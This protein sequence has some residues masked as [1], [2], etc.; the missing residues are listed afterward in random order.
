M[1]CESVVAWSES[2]VVLVVLGK[3]CRRSSSL[4]GGS[5]GVG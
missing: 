2:V 3:R 1:T 4:L 5:G